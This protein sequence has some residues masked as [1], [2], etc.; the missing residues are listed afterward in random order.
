MPRRKQKKPK[1]PEPAANKSD[2]ILA[3]DEK[4]DEIR[5]TLAIRRSA[6]NV[7]LLHM[8]TSKR[9]LIWSNLILGVTRGVGFFLGMTIFGALVLG[10]LAL[11][12][13]WFESV[14]GVPVRDNM[15]KVLGVGE[16]LAPQK[17]EGIAGQRKSIEKVVRKV[18]RDEGLIPEPDEPESD[19]DIPPPEIINPPP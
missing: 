6:E 1:N 18:L 4:L 11:S 3:Q 2:V 9:R 16:D 19:P 10:I 12:L 17:S 8:L 15:E 14:T 13:D 7:D 5:E